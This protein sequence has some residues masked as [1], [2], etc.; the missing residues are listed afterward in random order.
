MS[1][2]NQTETSQRK[3][4]HIDLAFSSQVGQMELDQRFYYE[5][6]L[7]AHPNEEDRLST[8]FG[9]NNLG[10]PLWI[11]SMTGGTAHAGSI[12]KNLAKACRQFGL[13]MGLGSCRIILEDDTYFEDFNL[14]PIIGDAF[15]F[16]ANLGIAQIE[17][18]LQ[19]GKKAL[20]KNLVDRLQADGLII[21]VNPMQEWLQP[22]GDLIKSSPI[23][24]IQRSLDSFD[25]P[26]IVKEVGQGF[27]P[28]SM[29]KLLALPLAAVDFGAA[30]GTNFAKLE[31]S[32]ANDLEQNHEKLMYCGHNATEMMAFVA[33]IVKQN[34][35]ISCKQ[36][37][38]SGGIKDYL[39]GHYFME[40]SPIPAI[41]AQASVLLKH[42][43]H[44]YEML[45][46]YLSTQ[47]EGLKM[48]RKFLFIKN[49]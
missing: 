47:V 49:D 32:R 42:A 35:H 34:N 2:E 4:D 31:L 38:V 11:S 16:Y 9:N 21:H 18:L 40:K 5:P 22:E 3:K 19:S 1:N 20:I 33:N 12:N 17:N 29:E 15:P 27:G 36:L 6:M 7:A 39:D 8:P 10:M 24:L 44:S 43:L 13:G 26:I 28:K 41:Y 23:D 46:A 25:F 37:I 48:A 14:R 45:E 30:G